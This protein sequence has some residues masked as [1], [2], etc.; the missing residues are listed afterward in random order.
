M[1]HTVLAGWPAIKIAGEWRPPG[2]GPNDDIEV[3]VAYSFL[4]APA[5]ARFLSGVDL[6]AVWATVE[7]T[8]WRLTLKGVRGKHPVVAYIHQTTFRD[9]IVAAATSLDTNNLKW[10]PDDH[11]IT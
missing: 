3:R 9:V 4:H 1:P 8:G 5:L 7:E 6:T 10:W 2:K 11:P